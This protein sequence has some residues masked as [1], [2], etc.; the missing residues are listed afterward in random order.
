MPFNAQFASVKLLA[1]VVRRV[2]D[3]LQRLDGLLKQQEAA[4]S[5]QPLLREM[6][7]QLGDLADIIG[8]IQ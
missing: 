1:Q 7:Q 6:Q 4:E 2:I 5:I 8:S 3:N